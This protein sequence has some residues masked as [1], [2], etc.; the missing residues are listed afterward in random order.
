MKKGIVLTVIL[1]MALIFGF[2][3]V[4]CGTNC[5][6]EA[7]CTYH[8]YND[9]QVVARLCD[10]SACKINRNASAGQNSVTDLCDCQ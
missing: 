1:A 6:E 9:G 10:N 4:G 7:N 8:K 2:V 3:L 5:S